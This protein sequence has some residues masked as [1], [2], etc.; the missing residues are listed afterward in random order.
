ME[1]NDVTIVGSGLGGLLCGYILSREGFRVTILEQHA[2]AGGNLQTFTREGHK[3]ETGVHY[4]GALGPGQTLNRYWNYFRLTNKIPLKQLDHNAF[5]LIAFKEHEYPFAQGFDNFISRLLP[6]F[7][8]MK[9]NLQS[10]IA[11]IQNVARVFPLYNLET[12]DIHRE[13]L[14]TTRSGAAFLSGL[15]SLKTR[16]SS[17]YSPKLSPALSSV[18]AGNNYLYGGNSVSPMHIVALI[19]HSFISGAYRIIGGSDLVTRE[20]CRTI[21]EHG[22]VV[23]TRREVIAI[24][25]K[26]SKFLVSTSNGEEFH[27]DILISDIHPS[28][29]LSMIPPDSIRQAYIKRVVTLPNTVSS[30]ILYLSVKPGAFPYLNYNYYYHDSVDPWRNSD[31]TN[32]E[33]PGMFLLSTGCH[34]PDQ[35]YADTITILTYMQFEKV[36]RWSNS[37]HG[38]R[39]VGYDEF[40]KEKA[41]LLLDLVSKRFPE[42]RSSIV[43]MEISTPLTYRDYT[44]T[45]EGSLYGIQKN[46]EDSLLTTILPKTKIPNL[47][48]TGQNTNLHGVLGVTISAVATCG[49]IIGL[50]YLLNKIK[51]E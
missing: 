42:L 31:A 51:N 35:R 43:L 7:P 14:Y 19:N 27:S 50:P 18:L 45:P 21:R 11:E 9:H 8:E 6:F 30:F 41:E 12:P 46:Y 22:G 17:V 25:I 44:G 47:Y 1:G 49:E 48:F 40:K 29:T 5:D 3:F 37:R 38:K 10:Y 24:K 36:D 39:G 28:R 4:I 34:K 13:H 32:Q 33:W 15:D 26:H 2:Q 20:L 23:L 16:K